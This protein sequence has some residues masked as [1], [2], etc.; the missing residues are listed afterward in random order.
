[1]DIDTKHSIQIVVG[2][3]L[4]QALKAAEMYPSRRLSQAIT[5]LEEAQMWTE[6]IKVDEEL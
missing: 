1:M 4:N 6:R 2:D 5:K 3:A